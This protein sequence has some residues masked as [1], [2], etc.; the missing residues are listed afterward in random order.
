MALLKVKHG[1]TTLLST[2]PFTEGMVY[3]V[4]DSNGTDIYADLNGTRRRMTKVPYDD[5]A[6]AGRVSSLETA[7]AQLVDGDNLGYGS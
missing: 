5:T 1:S 2:Q 3:F 6:L 4:Y 7:I